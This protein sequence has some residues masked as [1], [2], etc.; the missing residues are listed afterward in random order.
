MPNDIERT[1]ELLNG[2]YYEGLISEPAAKALADV[3]GYREEIAQSLGSD[4]SGAEILLV[5]ILV[6]DSLSI[7]NIAGGKPAEEQGHDRLLD[8]LDRRGG[9]QTLVQ[10]RLMN[11]GSFSPYRLLP[12]AAH[13]RGQLR[14]DGKYTPLYHQSL[15]TLG[16]VIAKTREQ[17]ER[18]RATR[19]VTLIVTDGV[20]NDS[21]ST[22]AA[23]VRLL[24]RDMHEFTSNHIVAGMGIG[25]DYD[26]VFREM[27]I[28]R[29]F[30]FDAVGATAADINRLFERFE[31]LVLEPASTSQSAY[32]Q[33]LAGS[34]GDM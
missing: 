19:T 25:G 3:P 10:T 23:H 22:T 33:L 4:G 17:E 16:S 13:L 5:T 24:V 27:G 21:S 26:A 30:R 14:C 11:R 1:T 7:A 8:V 18:G 31:T 2:T 15:L 29:R 34:S 20:N 28:P 32:V 12:Q 9:T 6:D